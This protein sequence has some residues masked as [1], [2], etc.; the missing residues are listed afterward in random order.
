MSNSDLIR[1]EEWMTKLA[2]SH[3]G[4]RC[5]P[6][7]P[8]PQITVE[9]AKKLESDGFLVR[10]NPD[11]SVPGSGFSVAPPRSPEEYLIGNDMTV[12]RKIRAYPPDKR[13]LRKVWETGVRA[14]RSQT[15]LEALLLK[16]E[17]PLGEEQ[18]P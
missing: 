2:F 16:L 15:L 10:L 13:T 4:L 14:Q 1:P 17:V 12:L 11:G 6:G 18:R 8:V 7:S 9:Q 3:E 5:S